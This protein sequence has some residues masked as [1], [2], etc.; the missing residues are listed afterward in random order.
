M[1]KDTTNLDQ[2]W[3]DTLSGVKVT[4]MDKKWRL[5]ARLVRGA[6]QKR[7]DQLA[8]NLPQNH[9]RVYQRIVKSLEEE[10]YFKK[11]EEGYF[12]K[13]EEGYFKKP[14]PSLGEFFSGKM[15]WLVALVVGASVV[16]ATKELLH[17]TEPQVAITNESG[18]QKE[19]DAPIDDKGFWKKW[20]RNG[21][22][23]GMSLGGSYNEPLET[24][25]STCSPEQLSFEGCLKLANNYNAEARFNLGLM[26]EQGLDVTQDYQQALDWYKKSA[27]LGNTQAEFN[28]NYLIKKGLADY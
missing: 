22:F 2:E 25:H 19:P 24:T 11:P 18:I 1:A 4:G 7:A 23:I 5:H 3:L 17:F 6:F 27:A 21:S 13:P 28:M 10:G 15:K 26:Y 14:S 16:Y 12:K 9:S 8:K 20:F